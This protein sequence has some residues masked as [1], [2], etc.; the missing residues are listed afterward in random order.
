MAASKSFFYLGLS[1]C[2]L[3]EEVRETLIAVA[4][5][6]YHKHQ[7][8]VH[9]SFWNFEGV[10]STEWKTDRTVNGIVFCAVLSVFILCKQV[11]VR[12]VVPMDDLTRTI[13]R[14]KQQALA[15]YMYDAE[16]A[17]TA[18]AI[19]AKCECG[20][21]GACDCDGLWDGDDKDEAEEPHHCSCGGHCRCE[22]PTCEAGLGDGCHCK[23]G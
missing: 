17:P 15:P 11:E 12:F 8:K 14:D 22:D 13:D 9:V 1:G 16:Q 2:E 21:H 3:E 18:P 5:L 7:C 4:N 10:I 6:M 23:K 20:G 19:T